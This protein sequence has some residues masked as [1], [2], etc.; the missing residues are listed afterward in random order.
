MIT[1]FG[2][3]F[4][5]LKSCIYDEKGILEFKIKAK[6]HLNVKILGMKQYMLYET[7]AE[8]DVLF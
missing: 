1:D 4:I 6:F 8:I 5:Y 2:N 3:A 7:K